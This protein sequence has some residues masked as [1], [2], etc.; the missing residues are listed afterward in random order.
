M[1][2][3]IKLTEREEK[4]LRECKRKERRNKVYRRYL[5]VEMSNKGITNLEIASILGVCND[6]LTDWKCIYDESGLKGLSQ[7]NYEGRKESKLNPYKEEL[8]EKVKKEEIS[9]LKEIQHFLQEK[10]SIEIEQSWLS[11]YCK[12]NSIFPTKKHD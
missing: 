11:R 6:T 3:N 7:L 12:K 1:R 4:E 2:A 10:Y 8:R 5:Y 9:K